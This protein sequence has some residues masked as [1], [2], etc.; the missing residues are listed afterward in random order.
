MLLKVYKGLQLLSIDVALGACSTSYLVAHVLGVSVSLIIYFSLG[1]S[2][3]LTYTIDHLLDANSN[4][5]EV[6]TPRHTFHKKYFKELIYLWLLVFVIT[7]VFSLL[8]LPVQTIY[9]GIIAVAL[10]IVHL[11]L[12]KLL[13]SK[14]SIYIQKEL[15]IALTYSLGVL[16]GPLSLMSNVP[17]YLYL[18]VA[19]IFVLAFI[20]L[21]EFSYF[22]V[23]ADTKQGQSSLVHNIGESNVKRLLSLLI[24]VGA[25][26]NISSYLFFGHYYLL[27]C[28]LFLMYFV[29]VMILVKK[30]YFEIDERY[31]LWGDVVFLFPAILYFL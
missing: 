21:I 27:Q 13:G 18:V 6:V 14:I 7:G 26:L 10:V 11:V 2:V 15:G 24:G 31:R 3:W 25:I 12:V 4:T 17:H 30:S 19:Q 20:N 9:F 1:A 8:Y 16:I 5:K 29:L 23:E 28:L 22:E